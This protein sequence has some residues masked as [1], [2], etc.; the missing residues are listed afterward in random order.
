MASWGSCARVVIPW[1]VTFSTRSRI[2][3]GCIGAW[4]LIIAGAVGICSWVYIVKSGRFIYPCARSFR[5]NAT[6]WIG[7]VISRVGIVIGV[8]AHRTSGVVVASVGVVLSVVIRRCVSAGI[9]STAIVVVVVAVIPVGCV[10]VAIIVI[11]GVISTK[12]HVIGTIA[13]TH[14]HRAKPIVIPPIEKR[15]VP[16]RIVPV[17]GHAPIGVVKVIIYRSSRV[18]P[19]RIAL[20]I[21]GSWSCVLLSRKAVR[22]GAV[23][24]YIGK[25]F[26][27]S[28]GFL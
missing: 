9:G 16:I 23:L 11:V 1:R 27:S 21:L 6:A 19:S 5:A 26:W 13:P 4:R 18:F 24:V 15:I 25:R 17:I 14:I 7:Y 12:V 20:G 10:R 22:N 3:V 28:L 2:G 8:I